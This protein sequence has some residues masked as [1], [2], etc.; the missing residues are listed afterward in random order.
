MGWGRMFLLGNVG[1][2]LDISG[3][4]GEIASMQNTLAA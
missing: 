4:N 1:Q 3:L 2:Q